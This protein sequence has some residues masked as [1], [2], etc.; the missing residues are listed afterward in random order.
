MNQDDEFKKY[1]ASHLD[2]HIDGLSGKDRYEAREAY[3]AHRAKRTQELRVT[4]K[5]RW[6]YKQLSLVAGIAAVL[7]ATLWF[8]NRSEPQASTAPSSKVSLQAFPALAAP[9]QIA[10]QALGDLYNKHWP[11]G[12]LR[13]ERTLCRETYCIG[14]PSRGRI[15]RFV[16]FEVKR[17]RTEWGARKD[18]AGLKGYSHKIEGYLKATLVPGRLVGGGEQAATELAYHS[19]NTPMTR[20]LAS[21]WQTLDSLAEDATHVLVGP[22]LNEALQSAAGVALPQRYFVI[23]VGQQR[24]AFWFYNQDGRIV[25]TTPAA[26]EAE[27]GLIFFDKL[28]TT[29]EP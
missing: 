24:R 11:F 26:V 28:V 15:A 12:P 19:L 2:G 27:T 8:F 29:S 4:P 16:A 17:G 7:F 1:A 10:E 18:P 5:P 23:V 25:E 13:A 20:A 9:E 3:H 21:S 6:T 22:F 14:F